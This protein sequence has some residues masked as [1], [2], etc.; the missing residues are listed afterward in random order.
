M[1]KLLK[2][3]SEQGPTQML[4]GI[5]VYSKCRLPKG[6]KGAHNDPDLTGYSILWENK[7]NLL[8]NILRQHQ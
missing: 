3:C 6:H 2:E 7:V 1:R 5:K 4:W 8:I